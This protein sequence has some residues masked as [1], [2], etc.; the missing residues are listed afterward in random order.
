MS[1]DKFEKLVELLKRRI[2]QVV[3]Y[4]LKDPRVGF[5]TITRI[6]LSRDLKA[7]KVFYTVLGTPGERS[8]TAHALS[9]A[10]G[11]VQRE[12]GRGLRTRTLPR[13]RFYPDEEL[14]QVERVEALI[15]ELEAERRAEE[16]PPGAERAGEE[17][18]GEGPS[19]RSFPS[20]EEME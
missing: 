5:V 4:R 17:E 3:L 16:E 12:V 13:I 15:A 11:F 10:E 7:C 20:P 14:A 9:D 6:D 8:R 2:T 1:W 18:D 19:G